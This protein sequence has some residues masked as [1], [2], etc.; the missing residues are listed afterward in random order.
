MPLSIPHTLA[1]KIILSAVFTTL[2]L[3]VFSQST[4]PADSITVAIE[5]TYNDVS[6]VH[7]RL[8]GEG[9]RRTWAT[10][11]EMKIFHLSE[12][13]GGLTILE[14][15]G[16]LQTK[17]LRMQ[18][19]AGQQWVLRTIQKYPE[20][21]L[22]ATL[23]PTIAKDILQDQVSASHPY[24]ALTVPPLAEV[25]HIPHAHPEIVY[26]PDDPALGEYRKDFANQVFLFEEREPLDADKTDNTEKAQSRLQKD[27]DNRVDQPTVLRARLLDMLLGDYDRHEDQWRWERIDNGKGSVYEPVPR[28]RDHVYYKPSGLFPKLLSLHLLKANT[29]G[30]SGHIR[31]INRWNYKAR[32]FD[33]YFL[34]SL[35][36]E[37]WKTQI[38]YVQRTLTDSLIASAVKLLP[39][40]VYPLSGPEIVGKLIA[41]RNGLGQQTLKYYRFLSKTVEIPASDKRDHFEIAHQAHGRVTVTIRKI[42][43]EG[44]TGPLIYQRTFDPAVTHEIRL[45]GLGGAD[46]FAV[47]G[48]GAS[49]I[50]I[51]LIGGADVDTFTVATGLHRKNKLHI[52]DRSDEANALPPARQ[53]RLQT[54][55]DTTVNQFNKNS[56][57][58]NYLQPLFL[59]SYNKDYGFQL[60]GNFIYQKQAFR[61]DLYA[62]RRNLQV[63]YGFGNG[64][65]L[66][67]YTSNFR[68]FIGNN[69]L[70]VNLSSKGPNYTSNFFGVGNE[71]V[72][73]NS[74]DQRIRYY[75]SIYNLITA[76]IRLSRAYNRWRVSAGL[77]GQYY[78]SPSAKNTDRFL[79]AYDLQHPGEDVFSRQAYA[80]LVA[81]ATLDTRDKGLVPHQGIY[82][83]TSVTSLRRL[84][85]NPHTFG[86][87]FSEFS[88]YLN[89]LRDSVLVVA[90]RTGA[91]TTVGSAEYFQQ[92]K[93]GGPQSL[94]GFYL[95]RFTGKSMA[96]NNLELRLK[97]ADFTSYLLPG[98]LGLVLFNDVGRVWS[99]GESS[100]KWHDGY[101]GGIYF[102]PAQL[103]IIQAVAGFS[104][105]G[106]YPY[107]S[108]GFRF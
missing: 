82:W 92:L 54:A 24:A 30:Y 1:K 77:A 47:T 98:T 23:R 90:D 21:S 53:A 93:L 9:Y 35:S 49:P 84:D 88:F 5:P 36:E 95:W 40:A 66:L 94:R 11:V 32:Y 17:S 62:F 64:S 104:T 99:P 44:G 70:T 48:P 37:D 4:A 103:V 45:Y 72:F 69:D 89:P 97:L 59:A 34:N 106:T 13:K 20:K 102:S 78:H 76:D 57:R 107:I 67:N 105:E 15:G 33:R 26:V 38:A 91:G 79:S 86:Q 61:K 16:G 68:K 19:A 60:V 71:T 42:K 2:S 83:N 43:K 87:V 29:Q 25:L 46:V 31:S 81:G 28:D 74:G 108:A 50:T 6:A 14:K 55:A 18:D 65:L 22:P 73:I 56:F 75:R 41:R 7:R 80:G 52:Y 101:G 12:E 51:R 96:Y 100:D 8:L 10:P 39:G 3:E 63:S 27:N 58:Y 85:G